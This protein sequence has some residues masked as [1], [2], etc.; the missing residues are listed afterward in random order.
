MNYDDLFLWPDERRGMPPGG[1]ARTASTRTLACGEGDVKLS[2]SKPIS[3]V[4]CVTR[5]KFGVTVLRSTNFLH[6]MDPVRL[7][8]R[9]DPDTAGFFT[10][11]K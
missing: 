7:P 1:F 11:L 6:V 3:L 10:M 4:T 5:Q 2:P 8:L 9:Q